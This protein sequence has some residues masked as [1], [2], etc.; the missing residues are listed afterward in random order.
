[1]TPLAKFRIVS[2]IDIALAKCFRQLSDGAEI[3]VITALLARHQNVRRMMEIVVPL[4]MQTVAVR[5]ARQHKSR[6]IQVAFGDEVHLA[7]G[8]LG[9]GLH[10]TPEQ[11]EKWL[12]VAVYDSVDGI[13]AES[14]NMELLEPIEGILHKKSDYFVAVRSV[15]VDGLPPRRAISVG[16]IWAEVRQVIALR[17]EVVIDHVEHNR[18]FTLMTSVHESFQS[19]RPAVTVLHG[20]RVYAVVAPIPI[21]RELG[22]RHQLESCDSQ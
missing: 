7:S 21:A 8:L 5:L 11:F 20:E 22:D 16:E 14:I 3:L 9:E 2:S 19:L 13:Q 6:V 10:L 4:G 17:A 12:G 1:M 15:E 18:H